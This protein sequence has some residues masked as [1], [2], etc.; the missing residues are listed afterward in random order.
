[1]ETLEKV[2]VGSRLYG[3]HN[4]D[5]DYD[6]VAVYRREPR[7]YLTL[8]GYDVIMPTEEFT[9]AY[10]A[11]VSTTFWDVKKFMQ[12]SLNRSFGAWE[13]VLASKG[14]EVLGVTPECFAVRPLL[15]HCQGVVNRQNQ[16]GYMQALH[17]V[18][19]HYMLQNNALPDTLDAET[20]L[21]QVEM[22]KEVRHH[23]EELFQRKMLG[24][25][26]VLF[27]LAGTLKDDSAF[28]DMP[29]PDAPVRFEELFRKAVF[30]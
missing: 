17:F 7:E 6:Y 24:E 18:L 22:K 27:V 1:M 16:R 21:Q 8:G 14:K 9:L 30:E 23:V 10:G 26:D 25:K 19:F 4:A 28:K 15:Y 20:L 12:L 13:V 29:V 11:T 3:L 2:L 5:S